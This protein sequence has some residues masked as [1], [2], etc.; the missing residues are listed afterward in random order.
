MSRKKTPEIVVDETGFRW[1]LDDF[2]LDSRGVEAPEREVFEMLAELGRKPEQVSEDIR[3]R[4]LKY[5][6]RERKKKEKEEKEAGKDR[7]TGK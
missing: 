3:D 4:Y 5:L 6:E 1:N 2:D 7:N